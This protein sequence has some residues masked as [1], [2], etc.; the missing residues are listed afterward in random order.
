MR[1]VFSLGTL[2]LVFVIGCSSSNNNVG[3]GGGSDAGANADMTAAGDA[4]VDQGGGGSTSCDIATQTGCAA[5]EKCALSLGGSQMNPMV[6]GKCE[7]NGTVGENQACMRKS[8]SLDDNCQAGM[9]CT[10]NGSTTGMSACRKI[11][12]SESSCTTAG[13]KCAL[14]ISTTVGFCLPSCTPFSNDCG[15]GND[16]S[17]PFPEI[18]STQSNVKGFFACKQTGMGALYADCQRNS[19]CGPNLQCDPNN[20]WCAQ[21]CDGTHA[22]TQ[23]PAPDGGAGDGGSSVTVACAPFSNSTVGTCQ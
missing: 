21:L 9:F 2:S 16:C 5:G 15:S 3:G 4:S 23:P 10:R 19:D 17:A 12:A 8:G 13:Q 7:P 18:G 11:C 22:C 6:V 14:T 1:S 20:S